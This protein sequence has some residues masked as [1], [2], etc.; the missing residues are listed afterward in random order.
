MKK[1]SIIFPYVALA[2]ILLVAYGYIHCPK[3]TQTLDNIAG[4]LYNIST[5]LLTIVNIWVFIKLTRSISDEEGSRVKIQIQ[6]QKNTAKMQYLLE[7]IKEFNDVINR[8]LTPQPQ[9]TMVS[10]LSPIVYC[11][12]YI[13]SFYTTKLALF[14][15]DYESELAKKIHKL[16]YNLNQ[17]HNKA[18]DSKQQIAKEE[19]L[20]ILNMR[21]F[22]IQELQNIAIKM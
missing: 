11:T 18:L 13:E 1:F 5:P 14:G 12:T 2:T 15:L 21:S 17:L 9:L 20:D 6:A 22:I 16:H 10:S 7:T 3:N 8:G 4:F 19:I